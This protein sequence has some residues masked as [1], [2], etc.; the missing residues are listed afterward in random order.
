M[1][2]FS[3]ALRQLSCDVSFKPQWN[4]RSRAIHLERMTKSFTMLQWYVFQHIKRAQSKH[5]S[6]RAEVTGNV[7]CHK[8]AE[9]LDVRYRLIRDTPICSD[10]T[11]SAI[12]SH[13]SL[14]QYITTHITESS[15][16]LTEIISQAESVVVWSHSLATSRNRKW[17][18]GQVSASYEAREAESKSC[19]EKKKYFVVIRGV[20]SA[21]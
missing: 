8:S 5:T 14:R 7:V 4:E 6:A 17:W 15:K 16:T 11:I 13:R 19:I 3:V 2:S 10:T 18:R 12:S 20:W 9:N 1:W 21:T